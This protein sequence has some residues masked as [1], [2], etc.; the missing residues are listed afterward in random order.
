MTKQDEIKILKGLASQDTYFAQF[1]GEDIEKMCEN[2]ANDFPIEMGTEFNAKSEVLQRTLKE[3]HEADKEQ[4]RE[5][6]AFL[7]ETDDIQ[8]TAVRL[9]GKLG[10]IKIK[11]DLGLKLNAEEIDYLIECAEQ[12]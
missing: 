7:L 3:Q 11:R 9:A 2:I 8:G 4:K 10:V 12:A 5:L 1:F 6:A